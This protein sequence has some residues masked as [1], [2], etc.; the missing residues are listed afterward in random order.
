MPELLQQCFKLGAPVT[1]AGC[2]DLLTPDDV[3]RL[4]S[5]IRWAALSSEANQVIFSQMR[6][7][8]KSYTTDA[9]DRAFMELGPIFMTGIAQRLTPQTKAGRLE[10]VIVC[11][12][13]DCVLMTQIGTD[14]LALSVDRDQALPVFDEIIPKI[15]NLGH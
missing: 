13:K 2:Y 4:H 3:F 12:E 15:T 5:K 9:E 11:F 7:G 10:C 1:G 8:V 14:H 6:E